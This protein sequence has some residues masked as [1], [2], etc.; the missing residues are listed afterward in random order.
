MIFFNNWYFFKRAMNEVI[1]F[2]TVF[3]FCAEGVKHPADE[4]IFDRIFIYINL[5]WGQDHFKVNFIIYK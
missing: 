2:I 3:N 1:K 5:V 4:S